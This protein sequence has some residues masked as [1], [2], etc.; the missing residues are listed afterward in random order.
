MTGC[1]WWGAD[2]LRKNRQI[3]VATVLHDFII[4]E[5]LPG[6]D[7]EADQFW[8]GLAGLMRAFAPRI[9]EHLRFRDELQDKIDRYH[10]DHAAQSFDM[11]GYE[12]FLREIGYLAPEAADFTIRTENTLEVAKSLRSPARCSG[13]ERALRAQRRKCALGQSL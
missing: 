6:I 5:I 3:G 2:G 4:D 10:K 9:R 12:A 11:A 13:F 7:V 1:R 8:T